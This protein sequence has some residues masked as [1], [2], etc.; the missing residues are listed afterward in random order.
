[1]IA[2]A[3]TLVPSGAILVRCRMIEGQLRRGTSGWLFRA[4]SILD[5]MGRRDAFI[6]WS[7]A[8]P[9]WWW[10]RSL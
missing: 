10:G 4:S 1:M 6:R 7:G 2:S 9:E 8:L 3:S 5:E